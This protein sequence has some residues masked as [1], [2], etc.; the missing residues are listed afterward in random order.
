MSDIN[1]ASGALTYVSPEDRDVWIRMGMAL[2]SEFGDD[3]FAMW[4]SWSQNSESYK[5][6]D[7]K[8]AQGN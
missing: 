2:K 7:A 3:A 5:S 4:D 6:N 1:K 8:N